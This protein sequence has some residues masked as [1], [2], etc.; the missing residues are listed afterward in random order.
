MHNRKKNPC[1]LRVLCYL[2]YMNRNGYTTSWRNE[3]RLQTLDLPLGI[4]PWD[5]AYQRNPEAYE[6]DIERMNRAE[7]RYNR[8]GLCYREPKKI[9]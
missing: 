7:G 3:E 2:V 4:D 6:R 1:V 8:H 9:S 5:P